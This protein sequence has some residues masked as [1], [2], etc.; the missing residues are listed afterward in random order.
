MKKKIFKI[1]ASVILP[2]LMAAALLVSA[3][4]PAQMEY[5]YE[6]PVIRSCSRVYV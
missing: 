5:I 2:A 1:T 3:E 4:D 6:D